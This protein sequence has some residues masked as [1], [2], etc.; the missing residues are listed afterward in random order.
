M[1]G[2]QVWI[3]GSHVGRPKKVSIQV[4]PNTLLSTIR[5]EACRKLQLE[6]SSST[7][8]LYSPISRRTLDLGLPVRLSNLTPNSQLELKVDTHVSKSKHSSNNP[9]TVDSQRIITVAIQSL[10]NEEKGNRWTVVATSQETLQTIVDRVQTQYGLSCGEKKDNFQPSK[11]DKPYPVLY[12]IN[13]PIRDLTTKLQDWG[14]VKGSVLFRLDWEY[15]DEAQQKEEEEEKKDNKVT[16]SYGLSIDK[17]EKTDD[18]NDVH[19]EEEEEKESNECLPTIS[20]YIRNESHHSQVI[21]PQDDIL[22]WFESGRLR[23][24][25]PTHRNLNP[26]A[27]ELP[28]SFYEFTLDDLHTWRAEQ[29][30]QQQQSSMFLTKEQ[31]QSMISHSMG[32]FVSVKI[33]LPDGIYIEAS[34]HVKD[35]LDAVYQL[36]KCLLLP[37]I[38][39]DIYL[40]TTPPPRRWVN[41]DIELSHF[42]PGVLFY[43]GGIDCSS[44]SSLLLQPIVYQRLESS[45]YEQVIEREEKK[46]QEIREQWNITNDNNSFSID[47]K[48][49]NH[50]HTKDKESKK[51]SRIPSWLKPKSSR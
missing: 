21:T 50:H 14:I 18:K 11:E 44:S 3:D 47:D 37:D 4:T 8:Q 51:T 39:R 41:K 46:A 32:L 33:K 26:C 6:N 23:I 27:V 15:R 28:E 22:N 5:E 40:F 36:L 35:T 2:F 49:Y 31:R 38:H 9:S 1:T 30:K 10:K 19:K 12:Y 24:Y 13:Q 7:L 29:Q 16:E 25:Q 48:E 34:F 45:P 20:N 42:S 43:L 17:N